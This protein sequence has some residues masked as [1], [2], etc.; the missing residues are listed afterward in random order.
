MLNL[1]RSIVVVIVAFAM[2]SAGAL[3]CRAQDD[4]KK[5]I[6]PGKGGEMPAS[7]EVSADGLSV[8][9]EGFYGS[10]EESFVAVARDVETYNRLRKLVEELPE[11]DEEFF[12]TNAVV[13]AFLG[14]RKSGGDSIS[15]KFDGDGGV[16]ISESKPA[17]DAMTTMALTNPFKV[18]AVPVDTMESVRLELD[19]A[20]RKVARQ[21]RL[22]AGSE[23][24]MSGG[25]AGLGEGFQLEGEVHVLRHK[26]LVTMLFNLKSSGGKKER[27]LREAATGKVD[28]NEATFSYVAGDTLVEMP[29]PAMT[30]TGKFAEKESKL[31]L[32]FKSMSTMIKDGYEGGGSLAALRQEPKPAKK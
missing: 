18:V 22:Q 30:A 20:W 17:P 13:A 7:L 28:G 21:Y 1:R 10:M 25:I 16:S 15:F 6:E 27:F 23:F 3:A 2:C 26:N 12:R 31:S 11:K 4:E 14:T 24:S 5:N 8:L 9:A 32:V 19:E 29:H